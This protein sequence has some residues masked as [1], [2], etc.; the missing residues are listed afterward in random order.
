MIQNQYYYLVAGLPELVFDAENRKIDLQGL[1]D[2]LRANVAGEDIALLDSLFLHYDNDNVICYLN[3]KSLKSELG[4]VPTNVYEELSENMHLF[5]S[6]IQEFLKDQ[7]KEKEQSSEEDAKLSPEV[8][9]LTRYYKFV[10]NQDNDFIKMWFKFDRNL[11]NILAAL[12]ARKLEKEVSSFLVGKDD[13]TDLLTKSLSADFGLRGEVP[14]MDKLMQ[15]LETDDLI[16][17]EKKIDLLRWDLVDEANTF[18]Y[19]NINKV[20]GFWIKAEIV[21]RWIKLDPATGEI[22]LKKYF[23]ELKGEFDLNATFEQQTEK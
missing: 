13:V 12:S 11:R 10:E 7:K 15:L 1:K 5:P 23:T 4:T 14:F 21:S 3:K 6:Y 19:F 2:E 8:D 20:L 9:L 17:R 22:L 18:N 16:E